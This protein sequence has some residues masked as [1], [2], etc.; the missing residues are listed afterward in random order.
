MPEDFLIADISLAS[1]TRRNLVFAT[2]QQLDLL[3]RAKRWYIDG[4][5]RVV[6]RPFRQLLS[7][8]AFVKQN[9]IVK[10]VPLAFAL[11]SGQGSADYESILKFLPLHFPHAPAVEEVVVDF[12]GAI[13]KA[14]KSQM[15]NVSIK[16]CA[17]HWAQ[18]VW[19]RIQEVGLQVAYVNDSAVHNLLRMFLALPFLPEE[20]ILPAFTKLDTKA[21]SP[22]L[23]SVSNYIKRTW[24]E[25]DMWPPKVWSVFEQ[26]VR[27]NNDC[28]GWHNRLNRKAR[29]RDLPFYIL[30]SLLR[31]EARV[32]S[33]QAH[34]LSQGK[35]QRQQRKAHKKV[36]GKIRQTWIKYKKQEISSSSLLKACAAIYAP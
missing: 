3:A 6:R 4:T 24:L 36:Q 8:H 23:Q 7:I 25:N 5:F 34:L 14:L 12:E 35:L 1:G 11:M 31:E 33:L 10:Q 30:I 21:Q 22:Q 2:P 29:R 18:A 15:P 16:G 27:T 9:G 20:H 19:R 28:E 26:S 13:W 17:F 32:V